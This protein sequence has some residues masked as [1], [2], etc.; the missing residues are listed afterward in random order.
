MRAQDEHGRPFV[1]RIR[2]LDREDHALGLTH[3][4]CV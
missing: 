2:V 4:R 1:V 3:V